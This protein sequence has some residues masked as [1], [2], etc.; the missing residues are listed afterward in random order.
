MRVAALVTILAVT[1]RIEVPTLDRLVVRSLTS[2][3]LLRAF[4]ANVSLVASI[5]MI[6]LRLPAI[7]FPSAG[8]AL[9]TEGLLSGITEASHAIA[10]VVRCFALSWQLLLFVVFRLDHVHDDLGLDGVSRIVD[11]LG[12]DRIF[13]LSQVF[14]AVRKVAPISEQALAALF[15]VPTLFSLI[16]HVDFLLLEK[17]VLEILKVRHLHPG[18]RHHVRRHLIR[19][20]RHKHLILKLHW[21]L[22]ALEVVC[23]QLHHV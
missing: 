3:R 19:I 16:L 6:A 1:E 13:P 23:L 15:V 4:L 5:L 20:A 11:L 21:L 18:L 2:L 7:V 14:I 12:L 9:A 10:V 17:V 22:V 8:S